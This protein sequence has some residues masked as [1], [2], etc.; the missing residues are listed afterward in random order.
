M[1]NAT[2]LEN[3]NAVVDVVSQTVVEKPDLV[4]FTCEFNN[5]E[6]G[7]DAAT[8]LM[9][10]YN[11]HNRKTIPSRLKKYANDFLNGNW[12]ETYEQITIGVNKKGEYS[13]I[14]GQHRLLAF[15]QACSLFNDAKKGT[16]PVK[17]IKL[18]VTVTIGVPDSE[19]DKFDLGKSRTDG[20]IIFRD[21]SFDKVRGRWAEK[22]T[23]KKKWS[24]ALAVAAR[25]VWL[26]EQGA[27]VSSAKSFSSAEILEYVK[28]YHPELPRFVTNTLDIDAD[29]EGAGGLKMSLG[30]IAAL[31]YVACLEPDGTL[32]GDCEDC[33]FD[34][35]NKLA[36]SVNLE[37]GSPAHSIAAYWGK[38]VAE[39]GSKD[40]DRDWIAPFVRALRAELANE[41]LTIK[42][43][44]L[45]A[46]QREN[47][48]KCPDLLVGWDSACY[49]ASIDSKIDAAEEVEEDVVDSEGEV[50][51]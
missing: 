32:T 9:A 37:K 21:D 50:S 27:T 43:V 14:S 7:I 39:P 19:A 46:K 23:W 17:N 30:Y 47:Y 41:P 35:I 13:I 33:L 34:F 8:Q 51:E 31:W 15:L 48:T 24:N 16:Y 28:S 4:H 40:R 29:D 12:G 10:E 44:K 5:D 36:Q 3:F 6:A 25:L 1:S 22:D 42:A 38:L 20:D 18:C 26:R 2:K 49:E 45:T 11:G